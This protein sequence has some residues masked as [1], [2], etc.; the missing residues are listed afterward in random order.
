MS[1]GKYLLTPISIRF[2]GYKLDDFKDIV[3]MLNDPLHKKQY[4]ANK[5]IRAKY[6]HKLFYEVSKTPLLTNEQLFDGA[7]QIETL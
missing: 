2:S 4:D 5:T 6:T 3:P 7:E 1:N